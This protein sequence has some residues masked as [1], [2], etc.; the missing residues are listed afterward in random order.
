M[1][2]NETI[3]FSKR[4]TLAILAVDALYMAETGEA[5]GLIVQKLKTAENY[6]PAPFKSYADARERLMELKAEVASLPEADRRCYYDQMCTSLLGFVAW[7]EKGLSFAGQIKQFI[8]VPAQ[9]AGDAELNDLKGKMRALL[10]KM[11]YSGDLAAQCAAWE[12]RAQ[13][14]Q[15]EVPGVFEEL[16]DE[17]WDRAEKYLFKIP[18]DKSDRMRVIPVSGVH[19]N[20]MCNYAERKV[21]LNVDPILTRPGLKHLTVHEGIPGHYL[22]FKIRETGLLAG[23]GAADG[24]ETNQGN[25]AQSARVQQIINTVTQSHREH[26]WVNLPL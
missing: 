8:H 2:S 18:A 10:N 22:Q 17:A 25:F 5:E 24:G 6:Q 26:R 4:F 14:P 1:L 20:A 7:R 16:M 3:E 23:A 12:A 9:P 19:F 15:D 11:G 21:H 13:V